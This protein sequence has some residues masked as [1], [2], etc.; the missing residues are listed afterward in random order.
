VKTMS[1]TAQTMLQAPLNVAVI[2]YLSDV[3]NVQMSNIEPTGESQA[4]GRVRLYVLD[5][6][7][8]ANPL[9]LDS[10]LRSPVY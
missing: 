8:C 6:V 2:S 1:K 9:P 5:Y 3:I 10:K 7:V 4:V